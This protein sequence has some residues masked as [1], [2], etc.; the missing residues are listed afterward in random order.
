MKGLPASGK[1]TFAKLLIKDNPGQYKRVNKDDLR[2]MIDGGKWSSNNEK[3]VLKIRDFIVEEALKDGKHVIVD[4]TNL[5][6]KH[7]NTMQRIAA[8]HNAV[9]TVKDF[10]EVAVETC[11][12][13][14]RARANS[15]GEKII[16]G[17]HR[18]FINKSVEQLSRDPDLKTVVICDLDGT[19]ALANGGNWYDRDFTKDLPNTPVVEMID[20]MSAKYKIVFLS[21]RNGKYRDQT[22]SWIKEQFPLMFDEIELYMRVEGDNRKDSIVKKELYEENIKGKYNVVFVADDRDQVVDLWR[23]LGLTCLQVNYGSF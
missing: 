11:I 6:S 1:T 22:N 4:D 5:H 9:V 23:S 7:K 10:T 21:G 8:K 2:N 16:R 14:D 18:N 19:I 13:R 3:F 15:V 12:E 20:Q 17:M